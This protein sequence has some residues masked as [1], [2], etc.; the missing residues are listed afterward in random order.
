MVACPLL[1]PPFKAYD[2][3]EH[4]VALQAIGPP[5]MWRGTRPGGAQELVAHYTAYGLRHP[6]A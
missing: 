4:V 6:L 3:A 1:E 5:L 2:A